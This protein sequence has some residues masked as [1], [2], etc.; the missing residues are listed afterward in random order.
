MVA[1]ELTIQSR[2]YRGQVRHRR[3]APKAHHFSYSLYM[4]CLDVKEVMADKLP[5]PIFGKRWYNPIRFVE[6]DYLNGEDGD[7]LSRIQNKVKQLGGDYSGDNI[8]MLV[9]ARCFGIYFS[10]ANF[11]FCYNT[12]SNKQQQCAYM[13]AEVSNTPWNQC[14]YYLVDLQGSK[15]TE[16]EFHVSPFMDLNMQYH[17]T[18]KPPLQAKD[19]LLV[20]I[21]NQRQQMADDNKKNKLFDATLALKQHS[22]SKQAMLNIWL[23]L[24]L[25][26]LKIV[27]GIYWQ[28]LKLF[29]KKV[30][31]ISYQTKKN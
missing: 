22:F 1:N 14:H 8:S 25:M 6:Q 31:F 26:T 30:P 3:F 23:A 21:E 2:I 19:E 18:V 16:K 10:P 20:H 24:P 15:V 29:I 7:L 4:L 17:W 11:Y 13:L 9:Q 12:D 5:G 28:A 27:S